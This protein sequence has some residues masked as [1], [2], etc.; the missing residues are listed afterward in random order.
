MTFPA[1]SYRLITGGD[2]PQQIG[3]E[4]HQPMCGLSFAGQ[5]AEN[6]AFKHVQLFGGEVTV[7]F[8]D[9][10]KG[11]RFWISKTYK[12]EDGSIWRAT[13]PCSS[14]TRPPV[15]LQPR[16]PSPPSEERRLS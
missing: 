16:S 1:G 5:M 4:L 7:M 13:A 6:R 12:A 11:G 3:N 10:Y 9:T 15:C 8:H 2:K 14:G